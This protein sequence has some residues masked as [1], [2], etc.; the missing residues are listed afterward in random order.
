MIPKIFASIKMFPSSEI[1]PTF[2]GD[3]D[4]GI[5]SAVILIAAFMVYVTIK[6]RKNRQN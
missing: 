3:M 6:S 5:I 1:M 2:T 4:Y